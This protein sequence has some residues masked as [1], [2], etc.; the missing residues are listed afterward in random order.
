MIVKKI[1]G[2]FIG[3]NLS[4]SLPINWF[5][6][7]TFHS[8]ST[9]LLVIFDFD[10]KSLINH[11]IGDCT[12]SICFSATGKKTWPFS[13]LF[14]YKPEKKSTKIQR[15]LFFS[16]LFSFSFHWLFRF[17]F[18]SNE[19]IWLWEEI[20]YH[21]LSSIR[22]KFAMRLFDLYLS[23]YSFNPFSFFP[24]FNTWE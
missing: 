12:I 2:W 23:I 8:R 24:I 19:I 14:A 21:H 17:F 4:P 10:F 7:S 22:R 5:L 9:H 6:F 18:W 13:G 16:V 11:S 1:S 20:F 3:W 15:L